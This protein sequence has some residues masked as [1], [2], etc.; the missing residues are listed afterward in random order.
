[1]LQ[2]LKLRAHV[3][4]APYLFCPIPVP[5]QISDSAA[6]GA[7]GTDGCGEGTPGDEPRGPGME[8]LQPIVASAHSH[9]V[10]T[11]HRDPHRV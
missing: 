9:V 5:L 6:S 1:M 4:S 10:A 2:C 3:N 11:C 8:Q 7:A